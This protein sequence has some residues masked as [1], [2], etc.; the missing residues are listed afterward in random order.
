MANS[1][2]Q[3]TRLTANQIRCAE[4]VRVSTNMV[5]ITF[6]GEEF[7]MAC[8]E[9]GKWVWIHPDTD[10]ETKATNPQVEAALNR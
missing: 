4:S 7:T 9:R 5:E 8:R 3:K 10:E 2:Y 6:R 1:G